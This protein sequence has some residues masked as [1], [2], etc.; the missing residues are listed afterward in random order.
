MK[1]ETSCPKCGRSPN[2]SVR[3]EVPSL[4]GYTIKYTCGHRQFYSLNAKVKPKQ[5]DYIWTKLYPFQKEG[6]EFVERA[7]YKALIADDMGLGKTVQALAAIRYN[8]RNLTPTLY[9]VKSSVKFQWQQQVMNWLEDDQDQLSALA[10][11]L[12]TG[13]SVILPFVKHVIIS[14]DMLEKHAEQICKF[15]FK[16]LVIDES[17]NFKSMNAARTNA[18]V[19]IVREIRPQGVLCLSGTPILNRASEFFTTLNLIA[20]HEW[21]SMAGFLDLWCDSNA[22][23]AYGAGGIKWYKRD[24]F[25]E[26]T[27]PYIIRR[28]KREVMKDLPTFRRNYEWIKIENDHLVQA[29]N[30]Q[31]KGLSNVLNKIHSKKDE[32][33]ST[34]DILARLT[35]LRQI[36]AL[37]KVP[38]IVEYV[39]AFLTVEEDEKIIIGLH[40]EVVLDTLQKALKQ[41]NPVSLTGK[42]NAQRKFDK[43]Q[44]FKNNP[45]Q[46]IMLAS[47]LA[48][49]EGLDGL[50][51]SC[52][53]MLTIERQWNLAKERQFES[54]L[55]RHGQ[56]KPVTNTL[57]LAK[58]TVDEYFTEV[59]LEKENYV[60]SAMK[61]G[62]VDMSSLAKEINYIDLAKRCVGNELE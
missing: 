6:V 44:D 39:D 28:E 2:G 13:D 45:R 40:H 37:S 50:Q 15:G 14:M 19:K 62:E 1:L 35:A 59:V 49:G 26:R 17:Q 29:Y 31:L 36:C 16:C 23:G 11:V 5:R 18:L 53:N 38:W 55:D 57:L 33:A 21:H 46:R 43:V 48:S 20:P 51:H 12:E 47:I 3:T 54:R 8:K 4:K 30:K 61:E 42:D 58:G 7:S 24:E 22:R 25:F 60:L 41:W 34:M 52:S 27:K 32:L 56:T 9:I 10:Q